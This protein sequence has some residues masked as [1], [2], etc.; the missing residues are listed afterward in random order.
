MIRSEC[1]LVALDEYRQFHCGGTADVNNVSGQ[2][3][4][5]VLASVNKAP[6]TAVTV[7]TNRWAGC[8]GG[9]YAKGPGAFAPGP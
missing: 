2:G 7:V 8:R 9:E 6:H 4:L 1:L 5:D 3:K